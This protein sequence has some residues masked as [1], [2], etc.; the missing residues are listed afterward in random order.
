[1]TKIAGQ[2]IF[3]IKIAPKTKLNR[4]YIPKKLN[5]GPNVFN[6]LGSEDPKL[7]NGT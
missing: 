3:K 1:M 6:G 2:I 5:S 7:V 4:P